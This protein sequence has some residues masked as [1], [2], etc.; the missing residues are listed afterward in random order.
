[1]IQGKQSNIENL[2]L[3]LEREKNS[4]LDKFG[5]DFK[6][7]TNNEPV[8]KTEDFN[9]EEIEQKKSLEINQKNFT[10]K[11][12]DSNT[13]TVE[14]T[15]LQQINNKLNFLQDKI[16]KLE[17]KIDPVKTKEKKIT[18]TGVYDIEKNSE[19]LDKQLLSKK[20]TDRNL[21]QQIQNQKN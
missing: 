13:I 16:A 17:Q 15:W 1:M 19:F 12:I 6:K 10:F 8:M 14:K 4:V 20:N 3:S 5:K 21:V 2:E 7:D 9:I 11:E 18:I